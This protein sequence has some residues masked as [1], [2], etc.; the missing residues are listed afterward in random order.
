MERALRTAFRGREPTMTEKILFVDDEPAVLEG[1]KRLLGRE[2]AIDTAIGGESGLAA[3]ADSGPYAVVISDM[4]M[5]GMNGAQFLAKVR[6]VAPTAVRLALTGYVD[7]DTAM[8]AVN[9][10]NIFRFLTKPC[11]KENLSRAIEA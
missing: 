11:S 9:E 2:L 10:G 1:Y 8:S 6:E 4:R 3:I 5:P 7:I